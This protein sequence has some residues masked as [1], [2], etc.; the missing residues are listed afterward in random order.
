MQAELTV[1]P[2]NGLLGC[3]DG[4]LGTGLLGCDDGLLGGLLGGDEGLLG[5]GL[6]RGLL[7]EDGLLSLGESGL[8]GTGLLVD[9][10]DVDLGPL[11]TV[12]GSAPP[13]YDKSNSVAE[14]DLGQLLRADVIEVHAAG[15]V[16]GS[17]EEVSANARVVDLRLNLVARLLAL[18]RVDADVIESSAKITGPCGGPLTAEGRSSVVV[19]DTAQLL[20]LDVDVL[21]NPGPN[22]EVLNLAGIRIILNEQIEGGDGVNSKSLTV[23]ALHVEL[24]DSLLDDLGLLDG[25]II[26]AQ[27]KARLQC[28]AADVADL[29]IRKSDSPDPVTV[30]TNLTYT[31]EVTNNGPD[32]ADDVVVTD[33]LPAGVTFVSATPT[34]GSCSQMAGVVTCNLGDLVN[35]GTATIAIVVTPTA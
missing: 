7:G 31:L 11:P 19:A 17:P 3:D 27:S 5:T 21:A 32:G 22:T 1:L 30:N 33:T 18:L 12:E 23:N 29:R 4:L 26:I 2:D 20:D 25:D 9:G 10:L 28:P 16:S 35:G 24:D 34:Q 14:V 15:N 6:L 13:D 8:L